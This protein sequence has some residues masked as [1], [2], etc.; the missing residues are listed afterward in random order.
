MDP[1]AH[2]SATLRILVVDDDPELNETLEL[3]LTA[4]GL[5]VVAVSSVAEGI[6]TIGQGDTDLVLLD[7]ELAGED[8]MEILEHLRQQVR[9]LPVIIMTGSRTATEDTVIGLKGGA[10]DY[11]RKPFDLREILARIHAVH[12]RHAGTGDTTLAVG[13]LAIDRLRRTAE[14]H[15]Q[16]LVLTPREL[17][18]LALL[19]RKA[20]HEVSRQE[21]CDAVWA[22][23]PRSSTLD[24]TLDVHVSR[25]RKKLTDC[26]SSCII[27]T[28][29]GKGFRLDVEGT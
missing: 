4:S 13:D 10:D 23:S 6:T 19:A 2:T 29:W 5:S 28:V 20:G 16:P 25:L 15:G 12:R 21:V 17:E 24:N 11:V 8:G 7:L 26:P 14:C 1:S 22:D 9:P 18:L 3:G 27:T